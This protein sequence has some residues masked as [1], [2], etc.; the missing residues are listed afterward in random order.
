M[1]IKS[2]SGLVL[3]L[4]NEEEDAEI[5]RGIAADPDT[6]ELTDA[7]FSKLK[8]AGPGR[9]KSS[10]PKQPV[11]IRLSPE[12]LEYFKLMG[13]GWQTRIDEVLSDYVASHK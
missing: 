1:Q 13:K 2:K 6:Y 7:E 10:N 5:Y 8:Q 4:P 3:E 12:V 11:S 9:P